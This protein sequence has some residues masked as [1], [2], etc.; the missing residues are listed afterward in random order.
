MD[1]GIRGF[2][3]PTERAEHAFLGVRVNI[4]AGRGAARASTDPS[5][6]GPKIDATRGVTTER[7]D[8]R[9]GR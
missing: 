7:D 6:G 4:E 9:R 8:R 3:D 1:T 2:T 5:P